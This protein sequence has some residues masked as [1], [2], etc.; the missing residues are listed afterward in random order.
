MAIIQ[1]AYEVPDDVYAGLLTGTLKR[2]GSVVK[3][4]SRIKMH[5]KEIQIPKKENIIEV[6]SV[7]S[8][9][10]KS[11]ISFVKETARK[12]PVIFAAGTLVVVALVGGVAYITHKAKKKLT[13]ADNEIPECIMNFS[14]AFS[15][16]LDEVS[17]G[18]LDESTLDILIE[19]LNQLQKLS[20]SG[21][22]KIVFSSKQLYTLINVVFGYTN[23]LAKANSYVVTKLSKPVYDSTKEAI[24]GLKECLNI[25]KQIFAVAS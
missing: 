12:H 7:A 16:Y 22:I 3:D 1:V 24:S 13:E 14:N 9:A 17:S 10:S 5:L 15:T 2:F 19:E 11:T 23:K 21:E 6:K 20:D 4:Q 25:Q 8:S 18:N